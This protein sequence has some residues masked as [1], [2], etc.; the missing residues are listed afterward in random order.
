MYRARDALDLIQ[1]DYEPLAPVLDPVDAAKEDSPPIHEALGNNVCL[2]F[3]MG[4]GDME[5]TFAKA[6]HVLRERYDV[7]RISAVP[8]EGRALVA[9][10]QPAERALTVCT[11]TQGP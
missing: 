3:R 9:Q 4:Q 6:D 8:L 1:V 11:S 10:Y 5:A 7:P 2:R